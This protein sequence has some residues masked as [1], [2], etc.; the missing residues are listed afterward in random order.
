M[1]QEYKN[2]LDKMNRFFSNYKTVPDEKLHEEC[3]RNF[4]SVFDELVVSKDQEVLENLI[5]FFDYEFDMTI[6]GVT[7]SM[8]S[9]IQC[10]FTSDQ[11]IRAFYKKFDSFME[12]NPGRCIHICWNLFTDEYFEKFRKMF[13]TVKSKH[14][15]RFLREMSDWAPEEKDQINIL[16]NDMKKW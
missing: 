2:M 16:R 11:I 13:N 4:D 6:Q 5:D 9:Q 14:S 8:E 3:M 10:N 15:E 7:E 1:K 12:K